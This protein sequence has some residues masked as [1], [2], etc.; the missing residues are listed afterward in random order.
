MARMAGVDSLT[1]AALGAVC[2]EL[3]LGRRLGRPAIG[4]GALF[5]TLPDLDAL[6]LPFLD[7]A[8]DLRVHRGFSHS[9]LLLGLLCW[10]LAKPLARRWKRQKVGPGRVAWFLA[11][12]LGTH[13][14]IDCFTVY[15]TQLLWPFSSY[16]VSFDNLFIIDP[17]FTLPLLVA[18]VWGL[19]IPKKEWKKGR[20]L[21]M[22]AVCLGLSTLYVGLSF[23]ARAA[24]VAAIERDLAQRGIDYER[25]M[26]AP[27]PFGIL[28]WRGLVERDGEF[29]IGY[30]S[31]FDGERPVS[32][33]ILS[34]REGLLD[35]WDG[36]REVAEVR[37]FSKDWLLARETPRGL[38]LVDLRFGEYREWDDRGLELRPVFA[39]EYRQDGR[40]DRLRPARSERTE[41]GA[42][43][44]RL[45]RRTWGDADGWA[46]RPRLIGNPAV[47]QEYLGGVR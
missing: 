34:K 33:T 17:L 35:E 1:Q 8:W 36:V 23:A 38:W 19:R 11:L 10:L 27:A 39:W 12:T 31:L 3:V 21:R 37:R 47:T 46:D 5:G 9:L 45:W 26:V 29:W 44:A 32:W 42:M 28:L 20:G 25:R 15:G 40:G 43:A 6:L 14:L 22:A 16:P 13:V 41:A 24:A 30:R 2:G 7:T 18:V 4:W